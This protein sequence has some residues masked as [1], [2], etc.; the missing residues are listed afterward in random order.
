MPEPPYPYLPSARQ[1]LFLDHQ[2]GFAQRVDQRRADGVV[3][4]APQPVVFSTQA[5][6]QCA[7]KQAQWHTDVRVLIEQI[8]SQDPRPS[9]QHGQV[10]DRVYAM[11]LYDFDLR[12][13]YTVAGIE[14]LEL[15]DLKPDT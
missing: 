6:Q 2:Q 11:R 4:L 8:L 7:Q 12:W 3:V 15:A 10:V 14:V 5:A 9:Y 13:H 1:P